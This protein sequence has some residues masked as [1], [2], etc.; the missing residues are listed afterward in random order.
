MFRKKLLLCATETA[1]ISIAGAF[2]TQKQSL[3]PSP[4]SEIIT[5]MKEFIWFYISFAISFVF[6]M[7]LKLVSNSID[8]EESDGNPYYVKAARRFLK[9]IF[10]VA[11]DSTP[12]ISGNLEQ[13]TVD[14]N[15]SL[16]SSEVSIFSRNVVPVDLPPNY[17]EVVEENPPPYD[18]V[19]RS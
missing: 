10:Q 8:R 14:D 7:G 18:T 3:L 2:R 15:R 1:F 17:A 9:F 19:Q 12:T 6:F 4:L 16:A 5:E 11:R 13:V